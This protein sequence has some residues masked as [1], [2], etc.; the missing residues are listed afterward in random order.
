MSNY[1]LLGVGTNAKTVKGDGTNIQLQ[2]TQE[3]A[4]GLFLISM[5][6]LLGLIMLELTMK[7]SE[8]YTELKQLISITQLRQDI[9]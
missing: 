1:K 8:K 6:I 9:Y 7:Q 4:E 2:Y 5:E 3:I